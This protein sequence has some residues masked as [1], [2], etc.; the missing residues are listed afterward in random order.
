MSYR[1]RERKRRKR[2]AVDAEKRIARSAKSSDRWWLTIVRRTTCCARCSGILREGREMVFCKEPLECLCVVCADREQ[3]RYR[4][5][6]A[7]E[8]ARKVKVRK[9]AAWMRDAATTD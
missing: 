1:S 7:W 5:S 6:L 9:G 8:R 4:P 2:V 3:V